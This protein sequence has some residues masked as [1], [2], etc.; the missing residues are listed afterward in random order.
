MAGPIR[1]AVLIS[2]SGTTLQNLIDRTADGRLAAKVVLVVASNPD[3]FGLER[4]RRAGIPTVCVPRRGAGS[5][6][7]F[8]DQVF[9]LCRDAGAGLVVLGGF[10]HLLRIPDDFRH[11]V[12]N[13]HPS[14]I[15]AF[16][17]KGYY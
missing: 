14:L 15:P 6:E 8:S 2:G 1:L 11:R 5:T 17:G 3:A 12:I 10:L 9:G 4:A 7:A 16:C 13:I